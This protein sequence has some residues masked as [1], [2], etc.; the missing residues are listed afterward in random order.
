MVSAGSNHVIALENLSTL[1]EWMSDAFCAI[2]TGS[3]FATRQLYTNKDESVIQA[4]RPI[5][6]NGIPALGTRGDFLERCISLELPPISGDQR[7]SKDELERDF[8]RL[9]PAIL[10]AL[11]DIATKALQLLPSVTLAVMPRMADF[12]RLGVAIERACG[13]VDGSFLKAYAEN[14]RGMSMLALESGLGGLLVPLVEGELAL[15]ERAPVWSVSMKEL[16]R[17]LRGSVHDDRERRWLP[18]T[19]RSLRSGLDRLAPSLLSIGVRVTFPDRTREGAQVCFERA[20]R[21]QH[22]LPAT[23]VRI[24]SQQE[25]VP[26]ATHV[27]GISEFL[28]GLQRRGVTVRLATGTESVDVLGALTEELRS[29]VESRHD[30]ILRHLRTSPGAHILD[31]PDEERLHPHAFQELRIKE[32]VKRRK[33]SEVVHDGAIRLRWFN[34]VSQARMGE[35]AKELEEES[36]ARLRSLSTS[37]LPPAEDGA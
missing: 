13:W 5:I 7:K 15:R 2:S 22:E 28:C 31:Y 25:K 24:S 27:E 32:R 35:V 19:E 30:E 36:R 9:Q 23:G 12:A 16:L 21:P 29:E 18:G 14:A 8:V 17:R 10:G 4:C 3:G 6:L 20:S 26:S 34:D 37:T 1:P 33:I 11:L